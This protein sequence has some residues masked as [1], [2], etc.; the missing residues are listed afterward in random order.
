MHQLLVSSDLLFH[1]NMLEFN[2]F[3]FWFCKSCSKVAQKRIF[4]G[5]DF[6]E[7]YYVNYLAETV[8]KLLML[9]S[10][11]VTEIKLAANFNNYK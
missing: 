9:S 3:E 4:Q 5:L 8:R 11:V 7:L 10:H 6:E 2:M 1:C